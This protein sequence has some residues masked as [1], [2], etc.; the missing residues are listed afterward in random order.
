MLAR[1]HKAEFVSSC[2]EYSLAMEESK[3]GVLKNFFFLNQL[4]SQQREVEGEV[5]HVKY[6]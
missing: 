4:I 5:H 6:Y 3:E 2:L 1:S